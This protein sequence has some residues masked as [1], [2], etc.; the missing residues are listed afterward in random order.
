M[1]R[2][3]DP[4]DLTNLP[5]NLDIQRAFIAFLALS[6]ILIGIVSLLWTGPTLVVIS[7]LFGVF[8]IVAA[9]YRIAMAFEN[10][11]ASAAGFVFNLLVAAVL[12]V[13]GIICLG[14]SAQSL[15][16]LAIVVGIGWIFDGVA[17]LVTAAIGNTK[18]RRGLVALSGVVSLVAGVGF[19]FLPDLSLAVF[20]QV[21]AVLLILVGITALLTLPRRPVR[22][23]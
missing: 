10:R 21:G 22:S 17:D 5:R 16:I 6:A 12:L 1:S 9:V 3:Y 11:R 7:I 8:L 15:G 14:N 13:T 4:I 20:V 19:L 2:I 18:G 23:L